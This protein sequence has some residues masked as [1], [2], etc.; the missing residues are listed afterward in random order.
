MA[1]AMQ[2]A[3]QIGA[4]T[5][6]KAQA[7]ARRMSSAWKLPAGRVAERWITRDPGGGAD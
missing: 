4:V 3:E 1:N 6:D 7:I 2:A 5:A